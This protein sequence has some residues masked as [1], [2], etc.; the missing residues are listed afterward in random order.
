MSA[1]L[2]AKRIV[3]V[4]GL[5]PLVPEGGHV[6]QTWQDAGSSAIYYLMADP[7]FS[8]LHRLAGVEIWAHHLGAPVRMLLIDTAGRVSEPVL[9]PDLEAG[10]RPQV[11]V[12]PDVWQAAEPLGAWSLVST[13]MSPPYTDAGVTFAR[14]ADFEGRYPAH[15]ERIR[16]FCRF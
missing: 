3:E 6:A 11:I 10:Q 16:R 7:D 2:T 4:L 8:G 5:A 14:W 12:P 15:Q 9:G 13:F 1:G